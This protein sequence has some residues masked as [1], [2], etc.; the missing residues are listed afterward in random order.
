[1]NFDNDVLRPGM[2]VRMVNCF[3][4]EL[5]GDRVWAVAS[6]PWPCC[7]AALVRLEGYPGGFC[8]AMLE[9]VEEEAI[10]K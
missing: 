1:M 7:G 3:E 6:Y 2:K 9:I 5:Y 8:A 4:A 10:A